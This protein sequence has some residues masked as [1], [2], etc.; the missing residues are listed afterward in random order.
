M[1]ENTV[2]RF[3]K[4]IRD[5]KLLTRENVVLLA[6]SGGLDSVVMAHLFSETN[7]PFAIAHCNFGL[8][9]NESD[10]DAKFVEELAGKFG[11][12]FHTKKFQTK[13]EAGKKRVSIQMAAR[14]LRYD[15]FEELCREHGYNYI[16]TA[17]HSQ[18]TAETILLNMV[19]GAVLKGLRGISPK[20]GN[21]VRPLLWANKET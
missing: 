21:V 1:P 10:V 11:V 16:A 3:K 12:P 13:A 19:K 5:K 9:G 8:R 2:Y 20:T 18:D 15:W 7:F 14:E 6:V 17:H 4:F